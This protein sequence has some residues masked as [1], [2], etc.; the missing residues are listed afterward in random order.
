[1]LFEIRF[2]YDITADDLVVKKRSM[3]LLLF[4]LAHAVIH[5][6]NLI[7]KKCH[8]GMSIHNDLFKNK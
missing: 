3:Y 6:K 2:H 4:S 5:Q 8:T 1:M 7:A